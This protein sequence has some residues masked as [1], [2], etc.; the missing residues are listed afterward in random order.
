MAARG[1]GAKRAHVPDTL[2]ITDSS[3]GLDGHPK[4]CLRYLIPAF[5]IKSAGLTVE[6]KA[7]L[8]DRLQEICG[9]DW[10]TIQ[11][12]DRHGQGTEQLPADQLRVVLPKK[13]SDQEKV[14][15]FRYS[16]RLPM[17]GVRVKDMFHILAIEKKFNE[18]YDHG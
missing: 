17:V 8:V 2:P 15:V 18:L 14:T 9:L 4:I 16:G 5:D 7:D 12:S 6:Q 1:R 13:F 10:K 3:A 11:R